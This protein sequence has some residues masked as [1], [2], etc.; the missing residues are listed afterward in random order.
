MMGRQRDVEPCESGA[1][2]ELVEHVHGVL[3]V[4]H[5]HALLDDDAVDVVAPNRQ[6]RLEAELVE[7]HVHGVVGGMRREL[8]YA[9]AA[10]VQRLADVG[11]EQPPAVGW[12]QRRDQ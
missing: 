6:P 8:R 9:P 2:H 7:R 1:R 3:A 12:R 10:D 11:Q 4:G 5:H